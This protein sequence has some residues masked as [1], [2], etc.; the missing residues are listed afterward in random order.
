MHTGPRHRAACVLRRS[1]IGRRRAGSARRLSTS[2]NGRL[3]LACAHPLC[4]RR[5]WCRWRF[6]V[7]LRSRSASRRDGRNVSVWKGVDVKEQV[8]AAVIIIVKVA[9]HGESASIWQ[10]WKYE[11]HGPP[12]AKRLQAHQRVVLRGH[13][14]CFSA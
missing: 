7:Y 2:S 9:W 14:A 8:S 4:R 1:R 10:L 12:T 3:R 5:S 6:V 13:G 11:K